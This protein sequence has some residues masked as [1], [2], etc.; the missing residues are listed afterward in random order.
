[1]AEQAKYLGWTIDYR[2]PAGAPAFTGPESISWQIYKNPVALAIG[3]ICAV[4]LEF[5]DPR[6]R[7]GV[8]DHSIFK[9]DPL[10]RAQRTG[11]AAM[12]GTYGPQEAA[13]R[14]IQG[15]NNMHAR[16]QGTTPDG[17]AYDARDTELLD[18]VSATARYGFVMAYHHFVSR[19]SDAELAQYFSEGEIVASLYG[20]QNHVRSLEDFYTMMAALEP[21]FEAHEINTEFLDIMRSGR[22]T[23]T[24]PKSIQTAIAH[25]AIDL[26]PAPVREALAL[27]PE[28]NL[29]AWQGFIVRRFGQM[30]N[31]IADKNSPAAQAC[32]RLGLPAGFLWFSAKKRA[33]LLSAMA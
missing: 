23:D 1:M 10:G 22:A 21:R 31:W 32:E 17:T 18:W 3:G 7:S 9:Q 30:S 14:V 28:Y 4:L 12:V 5:A 13:R 11:T 2:T 27:G 24:L 15:V 16:V 6:I 20:V 8:W 26:L 25:A 29:T 33:K 19:L